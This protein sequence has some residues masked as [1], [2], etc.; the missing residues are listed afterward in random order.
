MR[1]RKPRRR[2]DARHRHRRVRKRD[3]VPRRPVEQHVL[4]QHHAD[5]PAQ[6]RRVRQR[7]VHT[8]HQNPAAFGDVKPLDQFHQRGLPRTRT[9]HDAHHR[10]PGDAQ[11]DVAQHLRRLRA[12]AE[13]RMLETDLAC[14]G[15]QRRAPRTPR[16]LRR[17]VQNV[18]QFVQRY[19]ELLQVLPQL[20][21]TQDRLAH[22]RRQHVERHKHPHRQLARQHRP[23]PEP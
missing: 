8:V 3:V 11:R 12:V 23:R 15:R 6:P 4:L 10:T 5:L 17:R 20:R 16:G 21:Q 14:D 2:D 13:R 22:L 19:A 9:P 7:Q 18:P 1:P